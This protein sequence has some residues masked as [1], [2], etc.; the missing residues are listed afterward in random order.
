LLDTAGLLAGLEKY[1]PEMVRRRAS[2]PKF[3]VHNTALSS[4]QQ[5]YSFRE[6]VANPSHWGRW[7][8][9][10]IGAHLLNHSRIDAINLFYWCQGNHEV[11]YILERRGKVTGLEIKN[12]QLQ[13]VF[14]MVVFEKQCKPYKVFLVGNPGIPWQEFVELE[15]LELFGG[16]RH[17]RQHPCFI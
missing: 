11:D 12:G 9:S 2:I 8:E 16:V 10:A 14:G 3:H 7:L 6:I 13:H 1:S 17:S 4:A 5:Q 15:P